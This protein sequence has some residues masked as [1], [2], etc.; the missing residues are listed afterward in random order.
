MAA[1]VLIFL[2]A[3]SLYKNFTSPPGQDFFSACGPLVSSPRTFR[4]LEEPKQPKKVSAVFLLSILLAND[5]HA[6]PGPRNASVYPCGLCQQNVKTNAVACDECSVWFHKTCMELNS[7]DLELLQRSHVQWICFKCDSM[8]CDSFTFTSF[9]CSSNM[10]GPLS[11]PEDYSLGSLHSGTSFSP[12]KAST[13]RK[14]TD[15]QRQSQ[16]SHCLSTSLDFVNTQRTVNDQ[17][18][19]VSPVTPPPTPLSPARTSSLP[20]TQAPQKNPTPEQPS[21]TRDFNKKDQAFSFKIKD[22][23]NL[24]IMTINLK[25]IRNKKAEF[26]A[27]LE[28]Y[29]PDIVCGTES[30]LR[31]ERPG[32]SK[33]QDGIKSSE[34]FPSHYTAYRNDRATVGGGVFVLAH[35]DLVVEEKPELITDCEIQW[36]KLQIR[37]RKELYL[38]TFYMPQRNEKDL[39]KLDESLAKLSSKGKHVILCGDFNCPGIDWSSL[40]LKP[41]SDDPQV[42]QKL[43]DISLAHNLSQVHE[44]ATREKNILDL[45]FTSN[46]TLL[47]TS[48]SEPGLCDHDL[49]ITDFMS[50]PYKQKSAPK[51]CYKFSKADWPQ[52]RDAASKLSTKIV[53]MKNEQETAETLWETFKKDLMDEIPNHIPTFRRKQNTSLP[54]LNRN[55]LRQTRK[56]KRLWNQAKRT[57]NWTNFY[58]FQKEVKRNFEKAEQN[59]VNKTIMDGLEKNSTKP[60]WR[61]VKA[62]KQD[63][64]GV[65]PLR[66]TGG[67]LVTDS[68]KKAE[69]LLKQFKSV[70]TPDSNPSPNQTDHIQQCP[71]IEQIIISQDGVTKLLQDIK[72]EKATGPDSIPNLV[73]KECAKEISPAITSIFQASLETGKL[74]TDWTNA[75]ISPIY[76]KGDK[77]TAENYRPVS[78]TSVTCKILEHI[79]CSHLL[80]HTD[81]HRILSPLNHGFRAGHSCK[82]QLLTTLKDFTKNFDKNIQTDIAILDF[83]KAFDTVPH[84]KLLEKMKKYG[85][86]GNILQWISS[87]LTTRKMKVVIDGFCSEEEKVTSGVPQ[88]TVLGPIL[89]LIHI[90]DLPLVV[91]SQV[92]LFAD[93]CLL[94]RQ[95][96]DISDQIKLQ[97]DL[98]S[99]ENWAEDWGMS[100]NAKKCYIMSIKNKAP[101]F[102]KLKDHI[103]ETVT[104]IPYLG[105]TISDD[106][107][108]NQHVGS[109]SKKASSTLG[110]MRRNLR[111]CPKECRKAAYFSLVRSKLE[112]AATVWDPYYQQDIDRL[113]N[114]QRRAARFISSDYR[115]RHEGAVT[116]MLKNLELPSLQERR[117]QLRLTMF[118]K[119][120][121]NLV[122]ALPEINFMSKINNK[123]QIKPKLFEDHVTSNIAHRQARQNNKCYQAQPPN[124]QSPQRQNSFFPKT[125]I[126]WNQLDQETIDSKTPEGFRTRLGRG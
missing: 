106:L 82:T 108:W 43:I 91:D 67:S 56:K 5:V 69:I 101:Y 113:E 66:N 124:P 31:G 58:A 68:K 74:P 97:K 65:A 4:A 6:N 98:K 117:R 42:Q 47:K 25:S 78:L 86:N 100:F 125:I 114:I 9:T 81:K 112:Y 15:S 111:S 79:I 34:I 45:V 13:P 3:A 107:K 8:N 53:K 92:R 119:I 41:K 57:K 35:Q 64:I 120:A 46:P 109:I 32:S 90:N 115:S 30:W 36:V 110:F 33:E 83:S 21:Q 121:N 44:S 38:G 104:S 24:R 18:D 89:F 17:K 1:F 95:I 51:T 49:L 39:S 16:T 48:T 85:I 93:D 54:W 94:Y 63:N 29:K 60:F 80:K 59:Y 122:P 102:Y 70:F 73:L 103:L 84:R 116:E 22:K 96:N 126:E 11:E 77:H 7:H 99:L 55:L 28:L 50:K 105:V 76:K 40:T 52:M 118:Y 88:G 14:R 87:F 72:T 27:L 75:N 61:Y 123:R 26:S 20:D 10:F 2:L 23:D 19:K 62:K 12:I 37:G 71:D